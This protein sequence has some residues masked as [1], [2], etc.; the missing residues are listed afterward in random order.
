MKCINKGNGKLSNGFICLNMGDFESC[1]KD[2]PVIQ[3]LCECYNSCYT[4]P[5]HS[6]YKSNPQIRKDWINNSTTSIVKAIL[7]RHNVQYIRVNERGEVMNQADIAKLYTICRKLPKYQFT[8]YT[9]R[10]DLHWKGKP[11]NLILIESGHRDIP[12]R[13]KSKIAGATDVDYICNWHKTGKKCNDGC[14]HCYTDV[15]ENISIVI[16]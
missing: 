11:D 12:E 4:D 6:M 5:E 16:H 10:S 3:Q 15:E 1:C 7:R 2:N 8:I 13:T 14:N 9:C